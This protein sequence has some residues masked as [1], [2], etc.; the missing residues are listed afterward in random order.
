M[1]ANQISYQ[2]AM[3]EREKIAE[4]KRHNLDVE[5]MNRNLAVYQ[6][7]QM[8]RAGDAAATQKWANAAKTIESITAAA[9]NFLN[10]IMGSVSTT[11]SVQSSE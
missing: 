8:K 5:D 1:T 6:A 4:E 7:Y 10:P 9:K 2:R 11:S 3:N